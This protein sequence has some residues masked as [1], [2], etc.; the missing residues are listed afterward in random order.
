[1]YT[2]YGSDEQTVGGRKLI[3]TG[4]T[5]LDEQ[6]KGIP[7]NSV[8]LLLGEPG[9][10]FLTFMHQILAMRTRL[11]GKIL[12][13]SLDRPK[14]EVIFD[15]KIYGWDIENSWSFIDISPTT[16]RALEISWE[17]NTVNQ[18][19]HTFVTQI[20]KEKDQTRILDT[21][22][23][24]ISSLFLEAEAREVFGFINEYASAI[25]DT[26]G[27]HFVS[28]VR[29]MHSREIEISM[30]HF[31]DVVFD[32]WTDLRGDEYRRIMGVRK[33][34]GAPIP[35]RMTLPLEFTKTG[36]SPD[37]ARRIT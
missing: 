35:P 33:M 16:T 2:R 13:A 26:G 28:M 24:T 7:S 20:K 9:S 23:N 21:V 3:R 10:G 19:S 34:R 1:M 29:G 37:T 36:I 6:I 31:C 5:T 4:I 30:V 15:T 11:G 12:Y 25:K 14:E 8:I 32:F 18:L 17:K 27:L 22:I